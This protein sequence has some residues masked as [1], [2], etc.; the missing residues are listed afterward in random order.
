MAMTTVGGEREAPTSQARSGL[1]IYLRRCGG[2]D[3]LLFE[4]VEQA[5]GAARTIRDRKEAGVVVAAQ[6]FRVTLSLA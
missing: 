3:T 4:S 1:A 6:Y 5:T 2:K